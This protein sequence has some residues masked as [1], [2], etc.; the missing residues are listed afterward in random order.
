VR[1]VL[2]PG[3]DG[4]GRLF[5]PLLAHLP[6]TT[7]PLVVSYSNVAGTYEEI[8]PAARKALPSDRPF[9]LLG[10]SFS[11]PVAIRL[12][13]ERPFGVRALVLCASFARRPLAGGGVF[14]FLVRQE[15]LRFVPKTLLLRALLGRYAGAPIGAEVARVIFSVPTSTLAARL[16]QVLAV[17]VSADLRRLDVPVLY[18]IARDDAIVST[19][20]AEHVRRCAPQTSVVTI[21]GPH[22]LL[23]TAPA[24]ATSAIASFAAS[25]AVTESP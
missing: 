24:Q 23:Q 2:L 6:S 7:E 13:A 11:G 12:A 15:T 10:E 21:A 20:S 25:L 5:Q 17:D 4:T 16:R 19:A 22:L 3:L 18:L 14:R 8:L 1:L 9:V